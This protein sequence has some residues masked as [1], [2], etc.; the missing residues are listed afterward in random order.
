MKII[1][2][3]IAC[4][5][6]A[7]A[8]PAQDIVTPTPPKSRRFSIGI[9]YSH[10]AANLKYSSFSSHYYWNAIDYGEKQM[11]ESEIRDLNS[12]EK[13]TSS[14]DAFMA[15]FKMTL[16][17]NKHW[18]VAGRISLG[19][20]SF[21]YR[22]NNIA[23][24]SLEKEMSSGFACAATGLDFEAGYHF[25]RRWAL[26]VQP[27]VLYSFGKMKNITDNVLPEISFFQETRK[28][29][30]DYIYTRLNL[31]ASFTTASLTFSTGPGFYYLYQANDYHVDRTNSLNGD[32]FRSDFHS[33]LYSKS[34]IDWFI[35]ADWTIIPA[36]SL[37]VYG[38][39]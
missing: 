22:V 29:N 32:S 10:I 24:D 25:S 17:S 7:P 2:I 20:T 35:S 36:L 11:Q 4:L 16:F 8:L 21:A 5:I 13:T 3:F 38:N 12:S 9:D 37:G 23:P 30:F 6:L 34:F 27:S 19:M 33:K 26:I 15:Y 31:S 1:Q 14:L 39:H 18:H 28:N